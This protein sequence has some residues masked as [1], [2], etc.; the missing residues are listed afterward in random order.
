MKATGQCDAAGTCTEMPLLCTLELNPVCGCDGE[1]Y[2][3]PCA[4]AA[5]L[6]S[7]E[8]MGECPST[9]TIESSFFQVSLTISSAMECN[10]NGDCGEGRYCRREIGQ[11]DASGICDDIPL[12]CTLEANP[13]CGCDRRTYG[14]P[15]AASANVMSIRSMG[16]CAGNSNPFSISPF[17]F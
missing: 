2:G 15:C 4:A 6:V 3:N 5:N 11:C 1:T 9:C 17:R 16:E 13:V 7:L 14:N 12:A 8:G 10:S